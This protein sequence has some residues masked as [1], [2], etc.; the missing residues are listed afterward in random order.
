M[1]PKRTPENNWNLTDAQIE[2]LVHKYVEERKTIR[3]AAYH[4]DVS[5]TLAGTVLK[6][7]G[8]TRSPYDRAPHPWK[9]DIEVAVAERDAN[10]S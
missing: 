5:S 4:A 7:K 6:H 8:L 10:Q 3:Q 9:K 2:I 1:P